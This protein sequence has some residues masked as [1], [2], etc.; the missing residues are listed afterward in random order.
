[1]GYSQAERHL[2][3]NQTFLGSNPSTPA[4][5]QKTTSYSEVVIFLIKEECFLF[6][7]LPHNLFYY[8]HLHGYM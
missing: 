1:M 4:K 6:Y 5:Q 7:L 3:L 8:I 2:A